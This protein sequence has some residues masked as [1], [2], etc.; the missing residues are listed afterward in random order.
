MSD[1]VYKKKDHGT[2][3]KAA[4]VCF[5]QWCLGRGEYALI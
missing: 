1:T 5:G 4:G 2:N 3:A